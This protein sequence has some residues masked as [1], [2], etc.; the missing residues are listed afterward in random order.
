[1]ALSSFPPWVRTTP[2]WSEDVVFL[3][4]DQLCFLDVNGI[5]DKFADENGG[6]NLS[7]STIKG[8]SILSCTPEVLRGFYVVKYEAARRSAE[9]IR[10]EYDCSSPEKI[11][12]L[13]MEISSIET[14]LLVVNHVLWEEP[15]VVRKAEFSLDVSLYLS[16][17]KIVTMCANCRKSKRLDLP[18]TWDWVPEFLQ[19]RRLRVSH[20]LCPRCVKRFYGD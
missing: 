5:W 11:R 19:D 20:G 1:M 16:P 15:S 4:D 8:S 18:E 10:L 9:P 2:S 13:R 6:S 14:S 12:L 17:D 7:L 3:L